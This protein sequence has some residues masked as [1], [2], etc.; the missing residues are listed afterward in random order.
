LTI[1]G[2]KLPGIEVWL[3]AR[4]PLILWPSTFFE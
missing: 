4:N 2:D 1:S 3:G